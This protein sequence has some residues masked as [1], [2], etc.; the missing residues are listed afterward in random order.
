MASTNKEHMNKSAIHFVMLLWYLLQV[1][2]AQEE[3]A[4]FAYA[5]VSILQCSTLDESWPFFRLLSGLP[6]KRAELEVGSGVTTAVEKWC[7]SS[8]ISPSLLSTCSICS[9]QQNCN[10]LETFLAGSICAGYTHTG[11]QKPSG[12]SLTM[13]GGYKC[14]Y[15]F[16]SSEHFQMRTMSNYEPNHLNNKYVYQSPPPPHIH[17]HTHTHKESLLPLP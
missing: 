1:R 8:F 9:T 12:A 16:C 3:I 7:N 5:Y 13:I 10:V 14:H 17:T 15:N 2:T 11:N 4:C 6:K